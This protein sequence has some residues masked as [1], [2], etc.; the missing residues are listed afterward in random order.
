M[1]TDKEGIE[2]KALP[3]QFGLLNTKRSER[4]F[5]AAIFLF[6]L[7]FPIISWCVAVIR[8]DPVSFLCRRVFLRII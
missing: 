1:N 6:L 7:P 4:F 8:L 5:F 3:I 2:K